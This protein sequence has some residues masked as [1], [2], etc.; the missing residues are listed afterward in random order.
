MWIWGVD[1]EEEIEEKDRG[2]RGCGSW[3]QR[4]QLSG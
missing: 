1:I 2:K 3:G 4:R